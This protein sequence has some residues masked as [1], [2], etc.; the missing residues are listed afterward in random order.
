LNA[1]ESFSLAPSASEL[2]GF[3]SLIFYFEMGSDKHDTTLIILKLI[4][5]M[6]EKKHF[7][8]PK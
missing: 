6:S 3:F 8:V 7:F 2:I 5:E 4:A 1:K